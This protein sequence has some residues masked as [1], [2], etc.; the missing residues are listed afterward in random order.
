TV[1]SGPLRAPAAGRVRAVRPGRPGLPG[2][3]D[4]AGAAHRDRRPGAVA[5]RAGAGPARPAAA[6]VRRLAQRG[7]ALA[8][9]ARG[10]SALSAMRVM[11]TV[12]PAAGHLR[13]LVPVA[14]ALAAAGHAVAVAAPP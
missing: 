14:R 12:Q 1:R 4:R 5:V 13:S 10:G 11:V 7:D 8:G 9:R 6:A 3:R 2:R